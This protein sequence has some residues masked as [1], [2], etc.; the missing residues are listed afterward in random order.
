MH[1]PRVVIVGGGQGGVNVAQG[2]VGFLVLIQFNWF[3]I[4]LGAAS[5]VLVAIYPFMKRITWWPQLFLGLA[6]NWGALVGWSSQAGSLDVAPLV[7]YVGAI[8]WTIGYDTIY[9]LQDVEDDALIGV[10][11]TARLF[12]RRARMIIGLF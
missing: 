12:G 8:L 11:S 2:L 6:F 7:L 4:G 9:A 5:L 10:K 3:T 1:L